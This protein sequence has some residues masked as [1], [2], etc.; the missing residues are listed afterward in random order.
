MEFLLIFVTFS[1]FYAVLA[2]QKKQFQ[3]NLSIKNETYFDC[4]GF[5]NFLGGFISVLKQ[6]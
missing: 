4:C 1:P 5:F 6:T 3:L 2:V